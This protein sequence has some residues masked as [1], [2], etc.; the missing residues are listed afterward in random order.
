MVGGAFGLRAGRTNCGNVIF[1]RCSAVSRNIET[2]WLWST[3][4]AV[5][6]I[7]AAYRLGPTLHHRILRALL[8]DS[9][10]RSCRKLRCSRFATGSGQAGLYKPLA[11]LR[12]LR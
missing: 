11:A 3:G 10:R 5:I 6:P 2:D 4:V 1:F 12:V 7:S 9:R 8:L